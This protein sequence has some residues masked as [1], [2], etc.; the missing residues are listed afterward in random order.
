MGIGNEF[1]DFYLKKEEIMSFSRSKKNLIFGFDFCFEKKC[2]FSVVGIYILLGDRLILK[3]K[4]Q[5]EKQIIFGHLFLESELI[6]QTVTVIFKMTITMW[7][8]IE[9]L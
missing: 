7:F 6:K 2:I 9:L 8:I 1:Q 5:C 3:K 4:E